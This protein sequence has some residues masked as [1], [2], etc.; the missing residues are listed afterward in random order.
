MCPV[1]AGAHGTFENKISIFTY[2]TNS[3]I[4]PALLPDDPSDNDA[5]ESVAKQK[6]QGR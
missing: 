1:R 2:L 3:K 4:E 5:G 6:D